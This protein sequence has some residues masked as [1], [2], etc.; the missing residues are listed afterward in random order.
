MT[1]NTLNCVHVSHKTGDLRTH[2]SLR[3]LK[4]GWVAS[5][6]CKACREELG[7]SGHHLSRRL[8]QGFAQR[9]WP[10]TSQRGGNPLTPREDRSSQSQQIKEAPTGQARQKP[11]SGEGCGR[12]GETRFIL[13]TQ[14]R[15]YCYVNAASDSSSILKCT[16][17]GSAVAHLVPDR[18]KQCFDTR[19]A[20]D[21]S[22][23]IFF[24]FPLQIFNR[25]SRGS[26][27]RGV[28]AGEKQL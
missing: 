25:T 6:R 18:N 7:W 2:R 12:H 13:C 17:Q 23:L 22:L 19:K 1:N 9:C 15:S 16:C 10:A 5:C 28:T 8:L 27:N 14:T 20:G 4:F 3:F 21:Y 24:F 26:E 11:I